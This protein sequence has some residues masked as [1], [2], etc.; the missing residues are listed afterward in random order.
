MWWLQFA[1][2]ACSLAIAVLLPSYP[3]AD[4]RITHPSDAWRAMGP[5]SWARS[6]APAWRS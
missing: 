3:L 4:T 2:V 5:R 6:S 1:V